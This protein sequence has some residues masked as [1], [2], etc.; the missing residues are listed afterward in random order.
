M[1]LF[2]K[3]FVIFLLAIVVCGGSAIVYPAQSDAGENVKS[4]FDKSGSP[5]GNEPGFMAGADDNIGQSELFF[6]MILM[7]LLVIVLGVAAIYLSKKLLPK[8]GRLSG[9][10]IQVCETVH[11]GPRKAIHLI[12]IGKQTLLI[13]STNENIT[14]LADITGQLSE[15]DPQA[16]AIDHN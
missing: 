16:K 7:V 14:R 12:K 6:K 13:G 3:K 5:D 10:S 9:K 11:L 15:V 2:K 4:L 8:F 1:R